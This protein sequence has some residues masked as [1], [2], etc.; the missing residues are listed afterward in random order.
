MSTAYAT[1]TSNLV[2]VTFWFVAIIFLVILLLILYFFLAKTAKKG[3]K[4]KEIKMA[5][6]YYLDRNLYIAI[7][8]VFEEYY[9][10]LVTSD[11]TEVLRKLN[12]EEVEEITKENL[13]F[14]DTLS[15]VLKREK[16]PKE[17]EDK[18]SK[19]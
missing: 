5:K 11:S 17:K 15:K 12:N 6:K 16:T 3:P 9:V 1:N 13:N 10:T 2:D 8:K 14:V 7:I 18:K 4:N 19:K